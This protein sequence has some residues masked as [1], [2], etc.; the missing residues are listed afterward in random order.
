MRVLIAHA[1]LA[2][3]GGA[4]AVAKSFEKS[5]Q[6]KGVE[7]GLVDIT[8]HIPPQGKKVPIPGAHFAVKRMGLINWSIVC[9]SIPSIAEGYD[10]V[11]Y[12]FGEGPKLRKPTLVFRH[13]PVVFART[14]TLVRAL[15]GQSGPPFAIRK[16]YGDI[17]ASIARLGEPDPYAFTVANSIWTAGHVEKAAGVKVDRIVYPAA[18]IDRSKEITELT[19]VE[20]KEILMLGRIV[21]NKRVDEVLEIIGELHSNGVDLH[22]SVIGRAHRRYAKNLLRRFANSEYVE[23]FPDAADKVRNKIMENSKIGV[24]AYKAEHF[25]I[26]VAEMIHAGALPL[27]FNDGGVCELVPFEDQRFNDNQ[28]LRERIIQWLETSDTER[29]AR[30]SEL[31]KTDAYLSACYFEDRLD[32]VVDEFLH[33]STVW[34]K[35][36]DR[37]A[38]TSIAA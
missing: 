9:R 38:K 31:R 11:V 37:A 20:R 34:E 33:Y 16:A 26:A 2:A 25:G 1:Y 3:N 10:A 28:Q 13:A 24:H 19:G 5:F 18:N 35:Q 21:P 22:A 17:A 12:A 23:F 8:G 14:Q 27:V 6:K 4:E 15:A 30:I 7:V 36:G 29:A 32:G